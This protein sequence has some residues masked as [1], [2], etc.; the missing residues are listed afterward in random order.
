MG[1]KEDSVPPWRQPPP[2]RNKY[3][4]L[5]MRATHEHGNTAM[6]Y[7]PKRGAGMDDDA[8]AKDGLMDEIDPELRLAFSR[9][10]QF[11]RRT[12]SIET[13]LRPLPPQIAQNVALN[14]GFFSRI[15]TQ[16]FDPRGIRDVRSSM[17]LGEERSSRRVS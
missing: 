6:M 5:G 4:K 16:F 11:L 15:F 14:L 12:F 7:A 1:K 9:N 2:Q 13:L 10:F 17:G 8:A 3:E